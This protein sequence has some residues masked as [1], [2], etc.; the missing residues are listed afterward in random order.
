MMFIYICRYLHSGLKLILSMQT[1]YLAPDSQQKNPKYNTWVQPQKWQ[2]DLGSFPRQIIQYHSNPSLC[3]NHWCQRSWS[4]L[5][6]WKPITPSRTSTPKRCPF[7]HRGLKCK[8]RTSR[9]TQNNRQVWP[10]STKWNRAKPNRV[11]SREHVSY[12]ISNNSKD[13]S[14]YGHHQMVMKSYWLCSLQPK[15]E[16]LYSVSKN[17]TWSWLW[18][19]S[20]TSYCQIQA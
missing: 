8:S 11:L 4:W 16:K 18:L 2:N 5:V 12:S 19:R 1:I 17:K 10:W 3:P 6:L 13:D 7:H 9:D 15:M 20:S 14:T